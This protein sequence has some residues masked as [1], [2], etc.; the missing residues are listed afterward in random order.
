MK[1]AHQRRKAALVVGIVA[2][3]IASLSGTVFAQ[4]ATKGT[5]N[6]VGFSGVF[7]DN[8]Q[9]FIIDAFKAKHPGI[10][11]NY[12]QSK[13]SAETLAL[14]T[15]QRAEPKVDV[16]LID[17]SVA[18]KANKEELFTKL[19]AAKVPNLAEQPEWARIDGDRAVAFS[20]DNLAILYNTDAVKEPP[21]S[22]ADLAD[23]KYKGKIAAKLSD[24]RGVILLPIL[25]KLK[26]G[27][28][29][30]SIDPA[31]DF[32]KEVA[33]SV[34]TFEPAPD[35]YAVVQSGEVDLSICWNGRAQYL[36]DTQGGKIGIALPKEGSIGQTN[37][38][39]L[40]EG[41]ANRQAAELFVNY[42]LSAE[43]QATFA[44][45]SFYG[46]VN[47]KVALSEPVAARIYG[48]KEAQAAQSSLDWNF[49]AD[50]YSAW[51][52]RINREVIAAN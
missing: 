17:V 24:T 16:A 9:K 48:S 52:Q 30:T 31:I 14:L 26:G 19:D 5:V 33:P 49:V 38:I 11:V 10:E 23:P 36:H 27:D 20:Q 47:S 2:A 29:K 12:Q 42:A 22:W 34:S 18:I 41:S 1:N 7:A 28:Y 4:D 39:G 50:K 8:Y 45:K 37:T 43:A 51:I 15:L 44:E 3:G 25:T 40:V 32:L 13:N 46:P 6:I 35:C 21:T